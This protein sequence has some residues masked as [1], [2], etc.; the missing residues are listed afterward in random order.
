MLCILFAKISLA[1]F[2]WTLLGIFSG[3]GLV[4]VI[5]PR[6]FSTITNQSSTWVDT[7]KLL[8]TL[9]KRVDIDKY[10]LPF[11]RVLGVSVLVAVAIIAFLFVNYGSR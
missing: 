7:N 11:S 5:S 3:I 10:V 9:D 8:S 1:P 4:A 6:C 2:V